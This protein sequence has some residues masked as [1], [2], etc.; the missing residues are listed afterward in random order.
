[1]I[2][3]FF[4]HKLILSVCIIGNKE[5]NNAFGIIP[6]VNNIIGFRGLQKITESN[7]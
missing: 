1:M 2:K 4:V 5:D 3:K 7:S 6:Y